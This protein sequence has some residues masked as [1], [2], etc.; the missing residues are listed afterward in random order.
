MKLVILDRD[1]VINLDS[2]QY[3]K[4]PEEWKPIPGSLEAIARLNQAGFRVVVATNQSG[5]GRGL[6]RHGHAQRHARQDAQGGE[7]ARRAHRRG[8]L[9]PARPG[10]GLRTA[11]SRKPGMLLEIAE[12]FNVPLAGVPASATRCATC[13]AASAAGARPIL[14]LTGKG[15]QTLK[16]GGLPEGTETHTIWPPPPGAR[17][18]M[19]LRALV[20]YLL[21]VVIV[22][23]Y[24][25]MVM[26]VA[27]LPRIPR[28]KIIAG[29]PRLAAW[30]AIYVLGIRY[31]V[32]GRENIP[33]EPV[34]I[35]SKHSSAWETLAFSEIFPPH[36]YV[37]KRELMWLPFLG[38]GLALFNPIFINRADRKNAMR[39]MVEIGKERFAAGFRH[40]DLPR[41]HA[42][43]RRQTRQVQARRGIYRSADRRARAA[44]RAQRGAAVAAQLLPQAPGKVTVVIGEPM[45]SAGHAPEQLM[46]KVEDWIESQ[47]DILVRAERADAA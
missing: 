11:A 2:D 14:V 41:R 37:M 19:F 16:S 23:P 31:E 5:I 34:V 29:W 47:V 20:Y 39:R 26:C 36:V 6:V 9:L 30:L 43:R 1:G 38:W 15:E 28:W 8:V 17:R 45:A 3:I 46:R 18:M 33:A 42:H 4:S 7:P 10:R 22:V 32:R 35:L 21:L 40:H 24:W 12:R 13:E 44:G 27:W 25:V